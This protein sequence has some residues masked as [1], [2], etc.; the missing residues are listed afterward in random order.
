MAQEIEKKFLVVSDAWQ[1]QVTHSVSLRQGYL[2][3][4][5]QASVRVRL[6]GE[7]ADINIKSATLGVE[8]QEF[9]YAIPP[10][11]ARELLDGL[12]MRPMI[13]KTRHYVPHAGHLWEVDVFEGDNA[14]LVVAE[15]ELNAPTDEPQL[16]SWVGQEVSHD[17]RYY[18]TSL[19][20]HPFKN[21]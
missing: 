17:P 11:E 1:D 7:K 2:C 6:A 4:N 16:P 15:V 14:G 5:T 21:W 20:Q 18:N 19:V 9:E 8:R 10:Q 13:E 3:G 12:C